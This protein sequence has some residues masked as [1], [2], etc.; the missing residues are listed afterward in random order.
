M[1]EIVKRYFSPM[2]E[3]IY[4]KIYLNPKAG[5]LVLTKYIA[6][7]I[8]EIVPK[9]SEKWFFLRFNDD[10]FHIRLRIEV[11]DNRYAYKSFDIAQKYLNKAFIDGCIY[12]W[13]LDTYQREIERYG[14]N[15]ILKTEEYFYLNSTTSLKI[16]HLISNKY[17]EINCVALATINIILGYYIPD[18][19]QRLTYC[20]NTIKGYLIEQKCS[21]NQ[22]EI[23]KIYRYYRPFL[24]HIE[25]MDYRG[26]LPDNV[27]TILTE[28]ANLF[29]EY[30]NTIDECVF[31][32]M[33]FGSMI[34]LD[35]NRIYP[36]NARITELVL[37]LILSKKYHSDICRLKQN[38]HK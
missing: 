19:H 35:I 28:F 17:Y 20:N 7:M 38:Q 36:Y 33:N 4:F 30:R 27:S 5:D 6:P 23:N 3:W 29:N 16:L 2:S 21:I 10:G 18:I 12:K 31:A 37:Y 24:N 15:S 11:I 22:T 26:I 9:Y 34:H 8:Q 1:K 13:S 14:E 25:S 32:K